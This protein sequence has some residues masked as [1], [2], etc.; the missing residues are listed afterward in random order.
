MNLV[1]HSSIEK[2]RIWFHIGAVLFV[3]AVAVA[4]QQYIARFSSVKS[5]AALASFRVNAELKAKEIDLRF[6][7]LADHVSRLRK[8]AEQAYNEP[9]LVHAPLPQAASRDGRIVG[10]GLDQLTAAEKQVR[11]NFLSPFPPDN[12]ETRRELDVAWQLF[13]YM[14]IQHDL[15]DAIRWSGFVSFHSGNYAA[16]PHVTVNEYLRGANEGLV[17]NVLLDQ[18][19]GEFFLALKES[20]Q[21]HDLIWRSP[22][23]DQAGTGYIVSIFAPVYHQQQMQAYVLADV[24]LDFV[25]TMLRSGLPA[26]MQVQLATDDGQ[27]IINSDGSMPHAA[28]SSRFFRVPT[29]AEVQAANAQPIDWQLEGDHYLLSLPLANVVWHVDTQVQQLEVASLV[30]SELKPLKTFQVALLALMLLLWWLLSHFIVTPAL[31]V[32][33][34]AVRHDSSQSGSLP[35]IWTGVKQHLLALIHER[36]EALHLLHGERA[37][38]ETQV[39]ERTRELENQNTELEAFNF[40]VS[41]DLRAPLRAINGF[42]AVLLEDYNAQLDAQGQHYLGRVKS[43]VTRMEELIEALISLS[44]LS[45]LNLQPERLNL[46]E[47]AGDIMTTLAASQPERQV[48]VTV[49]P[50]I[51]VMA[52]RQLMRIALDNLLANAWKYSSKTEQAHIAFFTEQKN[53]ETV[54]VV[55]DNGAGFDM[56]YAQQLFTPF[57]R[58]HR[59]EEFEGTGIG[60]STVQRIIHRHGGRIWAEAAVGQ[61]AKFRFTLPQNHHAAA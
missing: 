25:M 9:A 7:L 23:F 53:G 13:P 29:A 57:Q 16:Y 10:Y 58:M 4:T 50:D 46:S 52:D 37:Q 19:N 17:R 20:L 24:Q 8:L 1:R 2:L 28:R 55:A 59:K 54:Y 42:V 27:P 26:S 44:R 15:D 31:Q 40:A 35:R 51:T 30:A 36:Q 41:H 38:L 45:R 49:Q 48:Q 5:Q 60:L 43:A 22:S 56:A 12:A 32:A 6:R 14:S 21:T 47:L 61:G 34:I 11:G 3:L 18:Y 33:D 39:R